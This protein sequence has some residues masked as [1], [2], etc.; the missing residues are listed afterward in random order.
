MVYQLLAPEPTR[1]IHWRFA[2]LL[3]GVLSAL[4]FG[5]LHMTRGWRD[6]TLRTETVPASDLVSGS[7][8]SAP[9]DFATLRRRAAANPKDEAVLMELGRDYTQRKDQSHAEEVYRSVLRHHPENRTQCWLF[10]M[11][12]IS[13]GNMRR[14]LRC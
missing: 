1:R 13:R 7:A 3:I 2:A 8:F 14:A 4:V 10:R 12:Y 9:A 5:G 6:K 11:F